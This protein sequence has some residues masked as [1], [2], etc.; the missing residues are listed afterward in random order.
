MFKKL[1]ISALF[2]LMCVGCDFAAKQQQAENARRD[3]IAAEL[4]QLGQSMHEKQNDRS[5]PVDAANN[6]LKGSN[7]LKEHSQM[8]AA[9]LPWTFGILNFL[10]ENALASTLVAALIVGAINWVWRLHRDRRDSDAIYTFI[11]TGSKA[12]TDFS[13]RSTHAIA[14]HTKLTAERVETLCSRHPK[15]RR[16]QGEKELWRLVD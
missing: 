13:F 14:S 3:A 6:A 4:K 15:I 10:S 11:M 12:A 5:S 8:A 16:N 9:R 1:Q 2:V 7:D